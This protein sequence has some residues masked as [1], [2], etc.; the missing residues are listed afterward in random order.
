MAKATKPPEL[1]L[2]ELRKLRDVTQVE[3]AKRMGIEQTHLS[4][5][6]R[7]EDHKVSTLRSYVEGLGGELELVAVVGGK[8]FRLRGV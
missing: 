5:F 7:R 8:R 1:T 4:A 2:Q 3:L 6:E